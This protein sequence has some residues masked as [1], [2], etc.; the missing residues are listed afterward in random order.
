KK[1]AYKKDKNIYALTNGSPKKN[2]KGKLL[3]L[4]TLNQKIN[5]AKGH[6][7]EEKYIEITVDTIVGRFVK[8]R[9][10]VFHGKVSN[11]GISTNSTKA[12]L[13][14]FTLANMLEREVN[15][16]SGQSSTEYIDGG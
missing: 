11:Y 7:E 3:R 13:I 1:I 4:D 15:N 8:V 14:V 12:I 10:G 9:N 2:R 5:H 16:P 6:F